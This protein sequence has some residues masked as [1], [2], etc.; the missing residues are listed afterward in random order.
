[1]ISVV[2][3]S[4]AKKFLIVEDGREAHLVYREIGKGIW[5]L[6]HTYVPA[7]FRGKGIAS[8]LAETALSEARKA[9]KKIIPN[10]SYVETY[11]KRHPEYSDLVVE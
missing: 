10:C 7:E 4:S 2:H 1:M 9:G 6:Y 11:L 3:D 8:H 5:D